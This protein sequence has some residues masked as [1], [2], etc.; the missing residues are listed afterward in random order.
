MSTKFKF[1]GIPKRKQPQRRKETLVDESDREANGKD[2]P[3]EGFLI[4]LTK[5]AKFFK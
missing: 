3:W 4:L 1:Q 2:A 5:R